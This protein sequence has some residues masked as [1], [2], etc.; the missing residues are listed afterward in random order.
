MLEIFF[1]LF[2]VEK[3]LS[4]DDKIKM[5]KLLCLKISLIL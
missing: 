4:V 1:K 2:F 5:K 3:I